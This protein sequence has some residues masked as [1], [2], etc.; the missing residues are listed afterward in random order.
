MRFMPPL[1][2][3]PCLFASQMPKILQ[4]LPFAMRL[5]A[6]IGAGYGIAALF[7]IASLA[8]PMAPASAAIVGLLL[9][10][11]VYAGVILW[12]FSA[13][14]V[15]RVWSSLLV[16]ALILS[17]LT[18]WI[19]RPAEGQQ[20]AAKACSATCKIP[21]TVT[22]DFDDTSEAVATQSAETM[23]LTSSRDPQIQA[24]TQASE[25]VF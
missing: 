3:L 17:A 16:L 4:W 7:T 9:S 19:L 23:V 10:F 5:L 8:F 1:R 6:A 12:A 14:S 24:T 15:I 22:V 11:W 20:N 2:T 25:Y 18:A 21:R 13:R